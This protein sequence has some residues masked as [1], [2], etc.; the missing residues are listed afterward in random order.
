MERRGRS[1][2]CRS[3]QLFESLD[4]LWNIVL[5]DGLQNV[6]ID[7][8]V[9]VNQPVSECDN[10]LPGYLRAGAAS[11]VRQ[12]PCRLAND[13]DEALQRG[14]QDVI[15]VKVSSCLARHCIAGSTRVIEHVSQQD[16]VVTRPHRSALPL[17]EPDFGTVG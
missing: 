11:L 14:G 17:E 15:I 3:G 5:N 10:F 16:S 2:R 9:S 6:A 7:S 1:R 8:E 13:L 4:Q 12:S